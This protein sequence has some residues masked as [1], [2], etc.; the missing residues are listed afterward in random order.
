MK[1]KLLLFVSVFVLM[2]GSV[3]AQTYYVGDDSFELPKTSVHGIYQEDATHHTYLACLSSLDG[4]TNVVSM[5]ALDSCESSRSFD[6]TENAIG[7]H[8]Y[9]TSIRYVSR[10][11]TPA[12]GWQTVDEG[13][14]SS[15]IFGFNVASIPED[16]FSIS[17][18]ISELIS[19][20]QDFFCST[21]GLFCPG[22]PSS[23]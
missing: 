9:V 10:E 16:T 23:P 7:D 20:L 11:W 15:D 18:W 2:L 3:F 8:T 6:P 17:D 5:D 13:I 1:N 22:G 14:D 12:T 19:D 4:D 21:F